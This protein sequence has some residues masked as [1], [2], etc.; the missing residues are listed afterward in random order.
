MTQDGTIINNGAAY[1]GQA[2][3]VSACLQGAAGLSKTTGGTLVLSGSNTYIGGTTVSAGV[4]Q[5]GVQAGVPDN[6]V[7]TI[8]GGTLDL[9]SFTKTTIAAVSF[10]G[11]VTQD[12]TIINNGAAY[13][14]QAGTVSACLQG[15]AGLSKTT[16]GTLVLSGSNGYTGITAINGGILTLAN[17]AAVPPESTLNVAVNNGLAFAAGIGTFNVGGL[18]GAGNIALADANN[19]AVTLQVGSKGANTTYSG[20]ISGP[21]SL[22]KTGSG[23]LT[24]SG[25]STYVGGTTVSGGTL[26]LGNSAALGAGTLMVGNGGTVDLNGCDIALPSGVAG[27]VITDSSVPS[28]PPIP[29]LL[30]ANILSG[31]STYGGSILKGN[32]GQD[33][34]LT[35]TGAGRLTLSGSNMY[36]GETLVSQGTL[37]VTGSLT[38]GGNVQIAAGAT[39]GG[40]G[41]VQGSINGFAGS[42]IQASGNLTLGDSTSYTGFNA[43]GTLTVGAEHRD[44][45]SRRLRQS[46]RVHDVEWWHS[47]RPQRCFARREFQSSGRGSRP[48]EH[49]WIRRIDDPGVGKP[50]PRR[51]DLLPRLQPCG[52][53]C[54]RG[55]RGDPEQPRPCLSWRTHER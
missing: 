27:A 6:T 12:G 21:G 46:G 13:G 7:L 53:A 33:L 44:L 49:Q 34:A 48:R 55:Q 51:R 8:S 39:L 45:E 11:G 32:N 15:A 20:T 14:G 24:L 40:S 43:A 50:Q 36:T 3:T 5:L 52:H 30:T 23:Q 35:K 41:L 9:G 4:L 29:T 42:T 54:H 19:A 18:S 2:G 47:F 10:Q 31:A 37:N 17:S 28:S 22:T 16:G 25:I 26:Q 38:G 1:G